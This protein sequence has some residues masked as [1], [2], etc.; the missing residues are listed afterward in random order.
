MKKTPLKRTA[1]RKRKSPKQKQRHLCDYMWGTII[2]LRDK[3]CQYCGKNKATTGHH[4]FA[5]GRVPHMRYNLKI[6]IGLC[7]GCHSFAA[8]TNPEEFRHVNIRHVGGEQQ[9]ETLK[10][11]AG[12]HAIKQDLSM[13]EIVLWQHLKEY[14]MKPINWAEMSHTAKIKFLR[15]KRNG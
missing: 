8:H 10:V 6:G 4:I 1:F 13:T 5:K 14:V 11:L 2:I 12:M 15:E 9:Y 7:G 3:I